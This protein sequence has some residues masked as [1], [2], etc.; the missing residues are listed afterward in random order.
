MDHRRGGTGP[1]EQ[2]ESFSMKTRVTP[3]CFEV[4]EFPFLFWSGTYWADYR[5]GE[6]RLREGHDQ[7]HGI[8]R[9]LA[10]LPD[11]L[12]AS[13]SGG[14]FTLLPIK[15]VIHLLK[16]LQ[17]QPSKLPPKAELL[18]LLAYLKRYF[19]FILNKRHE[20]RKKQA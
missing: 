18:I 5:L 14:A 12:P 6:V 11:K 15:M 20:T 17:F 2:P 8:E 13:R 19:N 7:R 9:L 16:P 10:D 1:R 3:C 4:P